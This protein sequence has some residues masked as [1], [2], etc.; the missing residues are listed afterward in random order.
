MY[1]SLRP[2]Q[3]AQDKD[4]DRDLD[5][6]GRNHQFRLGDQSPFDEARFLSRTQSRDVSPSS[7][8]D[9]I[10]IC[11]GSEKSKCLNRLSIFGK[12]K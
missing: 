3:E 7:I 4:A 10:Y 2:I 9:F 1:A 11:N 12:D 6:T 8:R 5:Y